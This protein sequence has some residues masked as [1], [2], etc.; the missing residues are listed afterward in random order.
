MG[1][2]EVILLNFPNA[3]VFYWGQPR[4][5]QCNDA[6][7]C[8][9]EISPEIN[10]ER[11]WHQDYEEAN[12]LIQNNEHCMTE[13]FTSDPDWEDCVGGQTR[14]FPEFGKLDILRVLP[15]R[16]ASRGS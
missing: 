6:K 16:E 10:W 12:S 1:A 14:N 4:L 2:E 8:A 11:E 9:F 15:P 5:V 7:M 13:I 3:V